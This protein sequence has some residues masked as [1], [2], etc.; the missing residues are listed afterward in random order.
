MGNARCVQ[1]PGWGD[2]ETMTRGFFI[3][4]TDTGVGKTCVSLGLMRE[5]QVQGHTVVGMKPVASGC[6]AV[7]N[8]LQNDD[9]LKLQS[10]SSFP[11]KYSQ[12]NPYALKSAIAPHLA[13]RIDGASIQIPVIRK[14]FHELSEG[15]EFVVVEGVGGWL[16]P[17]N[18][19]Q[20]MQDV[21]IELGLPVVLVVAIRLGCLN[22][23]MLAV[24]AIRES[25][26]QLAG[27]VANRVD[28]Q[29]EHADEVVTALGERLPAA[30]LADIGFTP[31]NGA[32]EKQ[33]SRIDL[34]ALLQTS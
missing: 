11:V 20:T 3:S 5:L 24:A 21:A 7:S 27:W 26:L 2:K 9:A 19:K 15:A 31:D 12:V 1:Y 6:H 13:A 25:G 23:A 33:A 28:A 32:L 17:I 22:H 34:A 18:A 4:G 16:V 10:C 8:G 30:L 29:C 14:S